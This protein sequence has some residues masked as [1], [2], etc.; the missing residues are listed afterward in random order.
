MWKER[1]RERERMRV[2]ETEMFGKIAHYYEFLFFFSILL[3][4][5]FEKG[6]KHIPN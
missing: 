2:T 3:D 1:E 4:P 6:K 5:K